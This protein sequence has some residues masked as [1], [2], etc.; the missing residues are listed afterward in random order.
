MSGPR[1]I[2]PVRWRRWP[3]SPRSSSRRSALRP[4][5]PRLAQNRG[6]TV[7]SV[8][9][10]ELG[11]EPWAALVTPFTPDG[12]PLPM[13]FWRNEGAGGQIQG[14][15]LRALLPAAPD[16]APLP[17][18]A[19]LAASAVARDVQGRYHL[20]MVERPE[21][22][23]Q[24]SAWLWSQPQPGSPFVPVWRSADDPNWRFPAAS[25][26]VELTPNE[27]GPPAARPADPQPAAQRQ[28]GARPG[29][30]PRRFCRTAALCSPTACFP[31]A[32]S[33]G[34]RHRPERAAAADRLPRPA[35]RGRA[36]APHHAGESAGAA[37]GRRCQRR[38]GVRHPLRHSRPGRGSGHRRAGGL[39]GRLYQRTGP[40][41]SG[42]RRLAAAALL[43]Q[44]R[45]QPFLRS[46]FSS[47]IRPRA[48][49]R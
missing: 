43:R 30:R 24:L 31:L 33:P 14:Q 41:D 10:R 40:R 48:A 8:S 37:P 27:D 7:A 6:L 38:A 1:T 46:E 20:L 21:A 13:L 34:Q 25:A 16:G 17:L 35:R 36:D 28:P 29:R 11:Q 23:P 9:Y 32:A 3:P 19:G 18:T 15:Q 49:T 2:S 4:C 42:R 5:C 12:E 22:G 44:C 39:A 26:Q 45:P 47:K